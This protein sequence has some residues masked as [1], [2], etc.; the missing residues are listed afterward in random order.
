MQ[1]YHQNAKTNIHIRRQIQNNRELSIDELA[2]KH[3]VSGQT[4]SK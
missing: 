3:G 2:Q 4:V 1:S